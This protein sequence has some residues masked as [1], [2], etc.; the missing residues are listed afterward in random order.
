M[1]TIGRPSDISAVLLVQ[2][3]RNEVRAAA[4]DA[5]VMCPAE[6]AP[7]G[8]VVCCS[9]A[10]AAALFVCATVTGSGG[11]EFI[12]MPS[13]ST[14]LWRSRGRTETM[15]TSA[16]KVCRSSPGTEH[17]LVARRPTGTHDDERARTVNSVPRP[18]G[19]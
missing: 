4:R 11:R 7:T 8:A 2:S 6:E 16:K 17:R 13:R 12:C 3:G 18:L 10:G 14:V 19:R 9:S 5:S 1:T 15:R